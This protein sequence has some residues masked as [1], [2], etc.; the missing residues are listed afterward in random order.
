MR[1]VYTDPWEGLQL[2]SDHLIAYA[3]HDIA[4]VG[5]IST[6]RRGGTPCEPYGIGTAFHGPG[7]SSPGSRMPHCYVSYSVPSFWIQEFAVGWRDGTRG[8]FSASAVFN[9]GCI[10]IHDKPGLGNDVD[11]NEARKRPYKHRFRPTIRRA[12]DTPWAYWPRGPGRPRMREAATGA[13][14]GVRV[15]GD[16][17]CPRESLA[18]IYEYQSLPLH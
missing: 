6:L 7:Y 3:R 12:D 17:H 11:E 2:I 16:L 9:D 15:V 13:L 10:S 4:D 1:E 5:G 18:R 14:L 8:V